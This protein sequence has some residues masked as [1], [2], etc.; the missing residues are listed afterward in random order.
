VITGKVTSEDGKPLVGVTVTV[1]GTTLG[2][3]T[4]TGGVYTI[5]V[6]ST[7]KTLI[8][9]FVG[10]K[11]KEVNIGADDVINVQLSEDAV[12]TD[13]VVVTAIGLEREKKSLGYSI[14][15][16]KSSQI[17]ESKTTNI[18]NSLTGKVAGVNVINTSGAPGGAAY[19]TIRGIS[20]LTGNNQPLFVVDG[21]PIDNSQ[22]YGGNPDDG[23]NN[24]LYG[25]AYSNR[26]IDLNP[27][28]IESM[29]ILKG[30]AATALYGIRAASGVIMITT[31][32]GK[33]G[34]GEGINVNVGFNYG[35]ENVN[36]LP[37]LQDRYVQGAPN[38]WFGTGDEGYLWLGPDTRWAL[39]WGPAADTMYWDGQDYK[40]DKNGHLVG[41]S[42]P[43]A[44]KKFVPYDNVDMFFRTGHTLNSYVNMSGA[45]EFGNFYLSIAD[46][47]TF[48]GVIP[49][50][51]FERTSVRLNASAKIASF[52]RATAN[53]NYI[54]SG[55]RRIQQG[56]NLSGVML[57]LLRTPISFDNSNGFGK[58]GA[59]NEEA[60]MF[61]P[62]RTQRTFRGETGDGR[63]RYDNPFWT[64]NMNPFEDDVNRFIGNV[65][66]DFYLNSNITFMTRI[67]LD[68]YSDVR[69]QKFAV[70]SNAYLL[71]QLFQQELF[72]TDL[73]WDNILTFDYD[74]G[75]DWNM[76][77]NLGHNMYQSIGE[78]YYVQGDELIIP[79]F[80]HISNTATQLVRYGYGKLRRMA[81]YGDLTFNYKGWLYLN[82]ALRNEWS[83][84][85]PED[86]NSFMFG[87]VN[88]SF[89]FTEAFE[90]IFKDSPISFGKIRANYAVVGKDAPMYATFTPYTQA[91]YG[92]GWTNGVSFPFAGQVG[93]VKG[94]GLGNAN[95]MPEITKS[96]E[97]GLAMN[98]L[99]NRIGFD[100]TY[101]NSVGED[102][103]FSVPIAVSSGYYVQVMN[104]G[105]ISNKGIEF[106]FNIT[107]V[108]IDNFSWDL[109]LNYTKN[110]NNVDKL[111]PGVDN[112]FLGGFVGSSV[113]AVAGKP[114]G[115]I[116]GGGWDRDENGNLLIDDSDPDNNPNYGYP[117]IADHEIA[118]GTYLPSWTMGITNS[119]NIYGVKFSFLFD[120]RTGGI[121][122]NGTKGALTFFGRSK[123]TED[124][125]QEKVFDGV[126]KSDGSPNDIKV[127]PDADWYTGN[128]GGFSDNTEDFIESTDWI[129]LREVSL[130]YTLPRDVFGTAYFPEITLSITGR[131]LWLST[132]YTGIDPETSLTGASNAQGLD[133]FQMPNVRSFIFGVNFNF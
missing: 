118:F 19:I 106:I 111:A 75:N 85:L 73:N 14:E 47:K 96:W 25:V 66:L 114:Y 22:S 84:T 54:K 72:S 7:A 64:V 13:E 12:L 77:F 55:G 120:F 89:V 131:N 30:P 67:G 58:D 71:G 95:L 4:K 53:L 31:K 112:L 88:A 91:S 130:A 80:Y 62:Q 21:I 87:T 133:Y 123:I 49:N 125:G 74:L 48:E 117:I 93:F 100:F 128:G 36:K 82:G 38:T 63:A 20:S 83:T 108:V 1:K 6:P 29:T 28:D 39:S 52:M 68:H 27:E 61:L 129:R 34:A 70:H 122:W 79:E 99:D 2:T 51:K 94:D 46:N 60:Y 35:M 56:S 92:D 113:R 9:R 86:N 105:Q 124:R 18:V 116:Y 90:N 101:Y 24:L 59:Y 127:Y 3:V 81:L 57:G 41:Q 15:E 11:T 8:F 110:T 104:A 65:Q 45:N 42:D 33:L 132:D 119:F 37:E 69:E 109:S 26:A 102:Q 121:M 32:K 40:Y 43:N 115:T 23:R 5:T 78:S 44:A 98:F 16:F 10:M 97:V 126:K 50:S 17:E 107:P 103:I 76:K